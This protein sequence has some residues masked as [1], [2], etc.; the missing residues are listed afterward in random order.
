MAIQRSDNVTPQRKRPYVN[1]S[2]KKHR[3]SKQTPRAR[4]FI[5]VKIFEEKKSQISPLFVVYLVPRFG[6][7]V[8]ISPRWLVAAVCK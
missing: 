1:S 8:I 5:S 3:L 4:T 7:S 2:H 6:V